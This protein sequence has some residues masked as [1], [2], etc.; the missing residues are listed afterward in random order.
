M[1]DDLTDRIEEITGRRANH[2]H[3]D[4]A[5]ESVV[6]APRQRALSRE[7]SRFAWTMRKPAARRLAPDAPVRSSIPRP[8]TRSS[9]RAKA[10]AP[11]SVLA[12][13]GCPVAWIGA[14]RHAVDSQWRRCCLSHSLSARKCSQTCARTISSCSRAT[15][16][17]P[18]DEAL[19][20]R[21][22][23]AARRLQAR[24]GGR[25]APPR[26]RAGTAHELPGLW[27]SRPAL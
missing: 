9:P 20:R 23:A 6:L 16:T 12:E 26:R 3:P 25:R 22:H 24:Q 11:S 14:A 10:A 7:C 17:R 4:I 18:A 19:V 15:E 21:R 13:P 2:I 8:A 1:G 5:I 27:R